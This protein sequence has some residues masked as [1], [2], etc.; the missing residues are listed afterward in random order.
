[1]KTTDQLYQDEFETMQGEINRLNLAM[2][3]LLADC[4]R[5][6]ALAKERAA[7]IELIT[8]SEDLHILKENIK[9]KEQN[10]EFRKSLTL[11]NKYVRLLGTH[12]LSKRLGQLGL[13]QNNQKGYEQNKGLSQAFKDLIDKLDAKGWLYPPRFGNYSQRLVKEKY[14]DQF[15]EYMKSNWSDTYTK[16]VTRYNNAT[17]SVRW[18]E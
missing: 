9:L 18:I 4:K 11:A 5:Q 13:Y 15:T 8:T 10:R 17:R 1:M 16:R 12:L 2:S 6:E 7:I 3:D 14:T